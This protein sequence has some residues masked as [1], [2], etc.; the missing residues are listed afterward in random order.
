MNLT[1][2]AEIVQNETSVINAE[3]ALLQITQSV[4]TIL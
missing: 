4:N 2:I 1:I 3:F